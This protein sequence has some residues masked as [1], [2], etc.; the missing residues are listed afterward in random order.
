MKDVNINS[1][2][3]KLVELAEYLA[4]HPTTVYRRVRNG[5]IPYF[6][7]GT[8]YRFDRHAIEE[9]MAAGGTKR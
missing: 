9:W 4:V 6:R 1:P 7:I 2:V 8:D 5:E 3:M